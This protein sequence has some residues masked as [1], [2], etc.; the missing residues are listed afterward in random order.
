MAVGVTM[1]FDG[2]T[3]EQ[4]DEVIRRMGLTPEGDAPDGALFHWSAATAD[5]IRVTDVWESQEQFERFAGQEI[6]PITAAVG[7]PGPPRTQIVPAHSYLTA[8][9]GTGRGEGTIA[10]IVDFDG[11]TLD[12]YDAAIDSVGLSSGGSAA[13]GCLFHWTSATDGGFRAIDVW[14]D[15]AT[16][17]AYAQSH[18]MPAAASAGLTTAPRIEFLPVHNYFT[19]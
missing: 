1:E 17:E 4:Y 3:L 13:P 7:V 11:A 16:F 15:R 6:G 18:I 19:S 9:E 8:G 5:G 14:S 10:V 12:Q 2:G